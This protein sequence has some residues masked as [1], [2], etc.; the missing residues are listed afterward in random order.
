MHNSIIIG[1]MCEVLS[2]SPS[3][4]HSFISRIKSNVSNNYYMQQLLHSTNMQPANVPLPPF[5][6]LS[7]LV[8]A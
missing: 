4:D 2:E 7:C 8:N 3:H 1:I 5:S 6:C